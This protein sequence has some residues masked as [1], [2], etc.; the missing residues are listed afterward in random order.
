MLLVGITVLRTSKIPEWVIGKKFKAEGKSIQ[1]LG[2]LMILPSIIGFVLGFFAGYQSF[3]NNTANP[4]I[5]MMTT[6]IQI[7]VTIII[8]F[9]C[10][11]VIMEN[12]KPNKIP[13][14]Q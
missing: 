6:T 14:R 2:F 13:S 7:A 5:I 11:I 8:F 1:K 12:L 3:G 10:T 4:S 9:I